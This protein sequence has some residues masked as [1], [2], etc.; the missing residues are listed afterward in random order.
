MSLTGRYW[1]RRY[2]IENWAMDARA[3]WRG[4]CNNCPWRAEPGHG[5][6]WWRCGRKDG[7]DGMHRSRN[8]VWGEDG[9]PEFVPVV[10]TAAAKLTDAPYADQPWVRNPGL[11]RRQQ[12]AADAWHRSRLAERAAE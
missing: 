1:R 12:R 11:N 7:H 2:R 3:V 8:Y 4:Y 9:R 6:S 10:G 5:Y